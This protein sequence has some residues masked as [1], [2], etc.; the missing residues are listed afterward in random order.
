MDKNNNI[1]SLYDPEKFHDS[2]GI[3]FIVARSGKPEKRILPLALNAL[4]RLFHRGAKSYDRKSGDGSGILI[5][6]PKTFFRAVLTRP[7][8]PMMTDGLLYLLLLIHYG[9]RIKSS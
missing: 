9:Y 3:G 8:A 6:L 7:S 2:C 4:K 1:Y 5:D